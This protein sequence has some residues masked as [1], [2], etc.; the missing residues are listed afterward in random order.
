MQVAIANPTAQAGEEKEPS[1]CSHSQ[2]QSGEMSKHCDIPAFSSP[3]AVWGYDHL[4]TV[5]RVGIVH[6]EFQTFSLMVFN[7]REE[8]F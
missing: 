4:T 5:V 1:A 6:I 8:V 2:S 3:H 7:E